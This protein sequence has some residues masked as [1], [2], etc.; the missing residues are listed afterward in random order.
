[1]ANLLHLHL[2][3]LRTIATGKVPSNLE[4]GSGHAFQPLNGASLALERGKTA[5]VERD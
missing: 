1:M 5:L 2:R 4:A 3:M